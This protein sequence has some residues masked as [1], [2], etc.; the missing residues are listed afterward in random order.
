MSKRTFKNRFFS[1]LALVLL[2]A[3]FVEYSAAAQLAERCADNF[4][5]KY[6]RRLFK[7]QSFGAELRTTKVLGNFNLS[8]RDQIP[9]N[10]NGKTYVFTPGLSK[11]SLFFEP[12]VEPL[13][14][15]GFRVVR[16]DPFNIGGTLTANRALMKSASLD[17]DAEAQA[18]V[19]KSLKLSPGSIFLVGHSRGAAVALITAKI[20]G[21][22]YIEAGAEL[23]D[24]KHD[25]LDRIF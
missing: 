12:L 16:F 7:Y 4:G 5:T 24:L 22:N 18:E 8:F 3:V 23:Q 13:L 11:S 6:E 15:A 17:F 21:P 20:L 14:A 10:W 19:I 9:N 1:Q 2:G 25:N